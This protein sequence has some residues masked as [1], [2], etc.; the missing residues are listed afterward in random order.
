MQK[1]DV[2]IEYVYDVCL[3]LLN[4]FTRH[5]L[6]SRVTL[7]KQSTMTKVGTPTR[8]PLKRYQKWNQRGQSTI[9]NFEDYYAPKTIRGDA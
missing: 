7:D 4:S 9:I 1:R 2:H 3:L 6:L 8:K 5:V